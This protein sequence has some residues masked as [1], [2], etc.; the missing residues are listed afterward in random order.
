MKLKS[1]VSTPTR[2][3]LVCIAG[4][5]IILGIVAENQPWGRGW[6]HDFTHYIKQKSTSYTPPDENSPEMAALQ[7]KIDAWYPQILERYP[8]LKVEYKNVPDDQNGFLKILEWQEDAEVM[9]KWEQTNLP[10]KFTAIWQSENKKNAFPDNTLSEAKAYLKKHQPSLERAMKIGLLPN[11]S[12][13][14]ISPDR[15]YFTSIPFTKNITDHLKLK[16]CIENEEGDLKSAFQTFRAINGW[17]DHLGEIE[18]PTLILTTLSMAIRLSSQSLIHSRILPQ[19][20]NN[21]NHS[22]QWEPWIKLITLKN[23]VSK[24][25]LHMWRGEWQHVVH[26]TWVKVELLRI[27]LQDY[28]ALLTAYT[29][30]LYDRID[31][32][33]LFTPKSTPLRTHDHLSRKSLLT[34]D[35]LNLGISACASGYLRSHTILRQYQIAFALKKLEAEGHDLTQLDSTTLDSLP[36]QILPDLRLTI[37]FKQRQ[38]TAPKNIIPNPKT[39]SF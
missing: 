36:T 21:K 22:K 16:A 6:W 3:A 27:N 24:N 38:I 2:L 9:E 30:D 5:L 13:A 28:E 15:F 20:P 23:D 4:Y 34:L 8:L 25:F 37:D 29:E 7:K 32:Q 14:G 12:N 17:A 10:D 35:L 1:L 26:V 19:L 33:T 39:I 18:T 11:Q 31:I